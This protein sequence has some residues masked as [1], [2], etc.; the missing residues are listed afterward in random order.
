MGNVNYVRSGPFWASY[1]QDTVKCEEVIICFNKR[2]GKGTEDDPVRIVLQV[3]TK[4]GEIIAERD[5]VN[6]YGI[7]TTATN[8]ED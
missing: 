3:F 7:T 1:P 8:K 2:L 6:E 5:A 4:D